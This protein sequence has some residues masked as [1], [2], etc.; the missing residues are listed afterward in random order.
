MPALRFGKRPAVA[1]RATDESVRQFRRLLRALSVQFS[2]PELPDDAEDLKEV[3][4]EAKTKAYL[5]LHIL[6]VVFIEV[7]DQGLQMRTERLLSLLVLCGVF[8]DPQS[9]VSIEAFHLVHFIIEGESDR[10][11]SYGTAFDRLP[12]E[13]HLF[14]VID[15]FAQYFHFGGEIT[16]QM[17]AAFPLFAGH[18]YADLI[19]STPY[20]TVEIPF[21][22]PFDRPLVRVPR[23]AYRHERDPGMTPFEFY[24][25]FLFDNPAVSDRLCQHILERLKFHQANADLIRNAEWTDWY[26][27]Q[28]TV[29]ESDL[30]VFDFLRSEPPK[31]FEPI[32]LSEFKKTQK[33]LS[34]PLRSNM[35]SLAVFLPWPPCLETERSRTVVNPLRR[36]ERR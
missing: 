28:Q 20:P 10:N 2:D 8:S 24:A 31:G 1:D 36:P 16:P 33:A 26:D 21:D 27:Y 4:E 30:T 22:P 5:L 3:F 9:V 25:H 34:R 18:H 19:P 17:V 11:D 12:A 29:I 7:P 35:E 23:D 14:S 13:S 32:R 6:I 15:S